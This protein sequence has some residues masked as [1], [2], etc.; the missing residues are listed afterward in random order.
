MITHEY[1][2]QVSKSR[3]TYFLVYLAD[4]HNG[5]K[6]FDEDRCKK[7]ISWIAAKPWAYWIGGG[8]YCEA[9]TVKDKRFDPNAIHPKYIDKLGDII[10]AEYNDVRDLLKPIAGKCIGLHLGNHEDTIYREYSRDIVNELCEDLSTTNLGASAMTR[11]KFMEG[12]KEIYSCVVHSEHGH[13]SG[14]KPGGKVNSIE[15]KSKYLMPIYSL[16]VIPMTKSATLTFFS[17]WLLK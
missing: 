6:N 15:D 7:L 2:I 11:L 13:M 9:I 16:R 5:T 8:D 4:L 10:T 17:A 1:I 14:R 3:D 12:K